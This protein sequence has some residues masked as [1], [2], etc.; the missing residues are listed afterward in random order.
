MHYVMFDIGKAAPFVFFANIPI[1]II[2]HYD[3]YDYYWDV[4]AHRHPF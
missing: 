3:K 2:Y 4:Y 1:T